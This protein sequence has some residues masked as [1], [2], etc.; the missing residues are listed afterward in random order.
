M[1]A[2]LA[3]ADLFVLAS[4]GEG[5][6][7]ALLEALAA[8]VPALSTDVGGAREALAPR[9][10]RP[11]AGWI[12]PRADAPALAAALRDLAAGVRAGSAE[13]R[14]RVDEGAWRMERWFTVD[15]MMDGIEAAL[16]GDPPPPLAE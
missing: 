13:V 5:F 2:V 15:A 3:A 12:V 10:G 4:R 14:A 16:R 1:A 8:R 9:R 7:V 6:S 11:A